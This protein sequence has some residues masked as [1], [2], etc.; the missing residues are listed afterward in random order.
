MKLLLSVLVTVCLFGQS[1]AQIGDNSKKNCLKQKL[2][3]IQPTNILHDGFPEMEILADTSQIYKSASEII[4]RS[5]LI[6]FVDLYYHVQHYLKNT[7]KID[8]TEP[9]YLALTQNQ[10]GYA[11]KGFVIHIDDTL[12]YKKETPYVDIVTSSIRSGSDRLM[13]F[14]QLYPHELSHVLYRLLSADTAQPN[15]KSVDMH[16]FSIITDYSTA[17]NEGFAEHL[18][19][20]ARIYEPDTIIKN[21]IN[22]DIWK[23]GMESKRKIT[24]FENDYRYPCRLGF[25]KAGM[26]LWY[27]QYEDFKR[28]DHSVSGSIK[29]LNSTLSVS[30][31][32]DRLTFRNS[33][34]KMDTTQLRN[35]VQQLKTEGWISSFFTQLST[36]KLG[37]VY[38]PSEVYKQFMEDTTVDFVPAKTFKPYQNQL[39]K[40]F[41]V[42]EGFVR[43]NSSESAQFIDFFEGYK[44]LFPEE[45]DELEKV[46]L[47][48][49]GLTYNRNLPPEIWLMVKDYDHRL[50][51]ID[52]FGAITVP[53]Y[54]F[55]LNAAEVDDLLSIKEISSGEAENIIAFR[56]EKGYFRNLTDIRKIPG[57]SQ[58]TGDVIMNHNFDEGYFDQLKE[59]KLNIQAVIIAPVLHLLKFSALYFIIILG[60]LYFAFYRKSR[61]SIKKRITFMIGWYAYWLLIAVIGLV[62]S[63]TFNSPIWMILLLMSILIAFTFI[64][65]R[66]NKTKQKLWLVANL[67]IGIL[68]GLSLF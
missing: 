39:L 60:I 1:I 58:H 62:V 64:L 49:S 5:I 24:G 61:R 22:R 12:L 27:Q 44:Q 4:N 10:G 52:P 6:E 65:F 23:I 40:Y 63:L 25:Y 53:V 54:T 29:Y 66:K 37:E 11:R 59:P 2:T 48:V 68:I 31:P 51:A 47:D 9:A 55:D 30:N 46:Y 57:L 45:K 14:T 56:R 26:L 18:E 17:F 36:G 42:M 38:Y 16:Y 15:S 20:L 28:Y 33:G 43:V 3:L 13:S 34:V 50:L 8:E 67:M 32:E 7:G 21:G 35:Q 19:N 41:M